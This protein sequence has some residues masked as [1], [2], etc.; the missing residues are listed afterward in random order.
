MDQGVLSGSNK[1][2]QFLCVIQD[3]DK[4]YEQFF[5]W[6]KLQCAGS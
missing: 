4:V 3:I 1:K 2:N 6:A 5:S